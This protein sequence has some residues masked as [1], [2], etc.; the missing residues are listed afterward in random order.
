MQTIRQQIITHLALKEHT[1]RDLSLALRIREKEVYD[2]LGHIKRSLVSQ[3]KRLVIRAAQC[4]DC[5]YVFRD[6]VRFT[7]PSKCPR[8][9]GTH[10]EDPKYSIE[11]GTSIRPERD[12]P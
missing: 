12:G 9:K 10:I 2:H 7:K 6:R 1:A 4:L 5:G 11:S 8:C 3:K